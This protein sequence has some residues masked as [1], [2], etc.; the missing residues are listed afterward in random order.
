MALLQNVFIFCKL[1]GINYW[2]SLFILFWTSSLICFNDCL[3]FQCR[4][5][6]KGIKIRGRTLFWNPLI[7]IIQNFIALKGL[8]QDH[9]YWVLL[10]YRLAK[11]KI[12]F[13]FSKIVLNIANMLVYDIFVCLRKN[14]IYPLLSTTLFTMSSMF[15]FLQC[16]PIVMH[17]SMT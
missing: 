17:L 10:I 13:G 15:Q 16:P 4:Q 3:V 5:Q 11:T 7:L 1:T 9:R 6:K 2:L 8:L 14:Y 12:I